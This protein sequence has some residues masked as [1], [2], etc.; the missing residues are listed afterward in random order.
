MPFTIERAFHSLSTRFEPP[1]TN[2]YIIGPSDGAVS[3]YTLG[4]EIYGAT[5]VNIYISIIEIRKKNQ[6]KSISKIL[7][8]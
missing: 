2:I 1:Y 7:R 5:S 8:F 3:H 6:Y 4:L